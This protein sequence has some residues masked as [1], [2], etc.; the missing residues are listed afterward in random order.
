MDSGEYKEKNQN[1]ECCDWSFRVKY[2]RATYK[3]LTKH[4]NILCPSSGVWNIVITNS[5]HMNDWAKSYLQVDTQKFRWCCRIV[6][7]EVA[8]WFESP[9]KHPQYRCYH[10]MLS[11]DSKAEA[12]W[13]QMLGFI[14]RLVSVEYK[15]LRL[16]VS[17]CV[18]WKIMWLERKSVNSVLEI[19]CRVHFWLTGSKHKGY[20]SD[21]FLTM[22]VSVTASFLEK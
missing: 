12:G 21:Q 18:V 13:T 7:L 15:S 6:M 16:T 10:I 19:N 3:F 5:E 1:A 11:E 2:S 9:W 8:G 22:T 4:L 17:R 14:E 20:L